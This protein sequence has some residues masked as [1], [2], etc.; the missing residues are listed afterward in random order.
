MILTAKRHKG[1]AFAVVAGAIGLGASVGYG[2]SHNSNKIGTVQQAVV[3][4]CEADLAPGGVR[5]I[6][7]D[8][9]EQQIQQSQ[10]LDYSR[11]FPSVPPKTL[12]RLIGAQ[13]KQERT[14]IAQLRG[15]D[16]SAQYH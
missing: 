10:A 5:Y 14:E 6:L 3:K 13:V 12:H 8:Q 9:I 7:A 1:L 11:F 15:V 4:A 16:C 2:V